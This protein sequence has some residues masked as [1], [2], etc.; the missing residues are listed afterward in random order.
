MFTGRGDTNTLSGGSDMTILTTEHFTLQSGRQLCLQDIQ[1][2]STIFLTVLSLS[3]LA[4]GY[5]GT[6]THFG[7]AYIA[8]VLVL[9]STLWVLGVLTYMRVLQASVEDTIIA[10]GIARIRHRYTELAPNDEKL[11]V[12]TTHDDFA[13]INHEMGSTNSWWQKLMP[14]Y[15]VISFVTSVLAGSEIAFALGELFHAGIAAQAVV[16]IATFIINLIVFRVLAVQLFKNIDRFFP[17]LY[18]STSHETGGGAT[19]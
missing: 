3:L 8:F 17:S 7:S 11:F 1:G 9:V 6:A 4:I 16:G 2:R 12:R 10:F 13:G 14:S 5:F 19:R 18:P 15:V